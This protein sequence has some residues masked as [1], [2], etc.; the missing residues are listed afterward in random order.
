MPKIDLAGAKQRGQQLF[1]GFT[2]GQKTMLVL[3]AVGT[4]VGGMLF[5][6]MSSTT[7]YAPLFS[8]LSA[9]SAADV[10]AALD[11]SGVSY[12]LS[13]GGNTIEVPRNDVYQTRISLSSQ[14]L[15]KDGAPGYD[16]LDAQGI[17]TSEFRQRI[18]FQ[19]AMEGE[20][21]RTIEAIDGVDN[22]IVHLVMP[23]EDLFSGDAQHPSASVLVSTPTDHPMTA[24]QV[25]AVVHLVASS[26]EGL[27]ADN[28][29]VADNSGRVLS[30]A[31]PDGDVAAAGDA[32]AA[33]T[34]AFENQLA[35][36]IQEMI[37]PVTGPNRSRVTV[38]A[39]LDYDRR[40]TT[41]ETFSDPNT[42]PVAQETTG[43]E[44][45]NSS[46]GAGASG[47][48][49][50]TPIPTDPGT[51]GTSTYERNDASRIFAN[52]KITE[53]VD[54]APGDVERLSVA[55]LL[56]ESAGIDT[57][58][59]QQL[60]QAGAGIDAT[61]G[62]TLEVSQLPF[63]TSATQAAQDELAAA[64]AAEQKG[65]LFSLLR[66]VASVLI[67]AFVL[68]F[69]WRS[70]RKAAVARYPVALPVADP[71]DRGLPSGNR[72]DTVSMA[73]H[74]ELEA[75]TAGKTG[76]DA[77]REQLQGQITDLIDRQPEDVASVLRTWMAER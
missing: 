50:T 55:V 29:T 44:T 40:S 57:R 24:G 13:N 63:D 34:A 68:F 60:V 16:L 1:A 3:A 7:E 59:V 33:S 32:R 12:R 22:A 2:S 42:A 66:T 14:G 46:G 64:Q 4:I 58:A 54:Q 10:T 48:L 41:S 27:E 77:Q 67:V 74:E 39:A 69:A 9:D 28:V 62:D 56:D 47:V 19:R 20:L 73:L 76:D 52:D 25:Q 8:N 37:L 35:Q 18:D 61:R 38:T 5:M 23:E 11:S 75:L 6:R 71:D 53:T 70:H 21:S 36:R 30:T 26:V 31:G 15:P 72:E 45:Y 49:G 65:Q 43:T 51:D 17:T